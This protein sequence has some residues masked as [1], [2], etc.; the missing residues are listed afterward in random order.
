MATAMKRHKGYVCISIFIIDRQTVPKMP[1]Q[2]NSLLATRGSI[3]FVLFLIM[4]LFV[5][6]LARPYVVLS[7]SW[8]LE[9]WYCSE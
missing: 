8:M 7:K 6:G 4:L 1:T 9:R 5:G 3:F 2:P